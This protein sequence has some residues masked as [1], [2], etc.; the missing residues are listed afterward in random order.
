MGDSEAIEKARV[1]IR[2]I[3]RREKRPPEVI[4]AVDAMSEEEVVR[5]A[6]L[7]A[8]NSALSQAAE[9]LRPRKA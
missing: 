3:Y 8:L 7:I 4:A 5:E 9:E 1:L 6:G 2:S